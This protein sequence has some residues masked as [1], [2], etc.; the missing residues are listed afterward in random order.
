M[1]KQKERIAWASFVSLVASA[2]ALC[3][4]LVRTRTYSWDFA[5]STISALGIITA[6]LIA[7]Q[8]K[9]VID[10]NTEK[11]ET[12]NKLEDLKRELEIQREAA[13]REIKQLRD[14][15]QAALKTS[16]I[17][18]SDIY[19][20]KGDYDFGLSLLLTTLED[21]D[22]SIMFHEIV[23]NKILNAIESKSYA[24]SS[25]KKQSIIE[26]LDKLSVKQL[27]RIKNLTALLEMAKK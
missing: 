23:L 10:Y 5:A 24:L 27:N 17:L 7:W 19:C 6:I 3:I 11:K 14:K 13:K 1:K 15:T 2:L 21:W 4:S 26:G 16:A 22:G 12:I 25:E 8:I 9:A 18:T 20:D